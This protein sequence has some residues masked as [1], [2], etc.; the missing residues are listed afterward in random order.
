H[1]ESGT[2]GKTGDGWLNRALLPQEPGIRA[3]LRAIA[4]SNELPRS[5]RGERPAIAVN[6]LQSFQ[7]GNADIMESLYASSADPRLA[8]VGKD[9][10]AAMRMVKSIGAGS[11]Q[12]PNNPVNAL[13]AQGG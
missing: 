12:A 2:P 11:P 5:L 1:M 9:P 6:N 13:Y 3:P 8:T 10:F 4:V 7:T